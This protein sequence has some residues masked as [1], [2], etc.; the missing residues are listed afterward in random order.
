MA[1]KTFKTLFTVKFVSFQTV[2]TYRF[3]IDTMKNSSFNDEIIIREK[4]LYKS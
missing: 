2:L 1:P 4:K 3:T